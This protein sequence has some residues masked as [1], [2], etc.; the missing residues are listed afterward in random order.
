M[1]S[2]SAHGWAVKVCD[3]KIPNHVSSGVYA[4]KK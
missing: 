3:G 2:V 1:T 4:V